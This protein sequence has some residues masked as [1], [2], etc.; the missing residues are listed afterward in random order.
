M[1]KNEFFIARIPH[2][3]ENPA[4]E[5]YADRRS[6]SDVTTSNICFLS[7]GFELFELDK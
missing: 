6:L 7:M 4:T 2:N 3:L 5:G 1:E